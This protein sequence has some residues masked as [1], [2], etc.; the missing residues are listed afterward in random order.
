MDYVHS[1]NVV[2][3][4]EDAGKRYGIRVTLPSGDPFR[5]LL[6]DDWEVFHWYATEAERDAD[7]YRMSTR[8]GYY[9]NSDDPSQVLEKIVR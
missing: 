3:P 6:G 9:R 4:P 5:R 2:E 7:V 1:H 8:H